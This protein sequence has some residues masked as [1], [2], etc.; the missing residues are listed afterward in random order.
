MPQHDDPDFHIVLLFHRDIELFRLTAA[1]CVDALTNGTVEE[2]ELTIYCDG[3]PPAMMGEVIDLG[4]SLGVDQVVH[5]HRRRAVAAGAPGN[6]AHRRL[7]PTRNRF[8]LAIEDDVTMYRTSGEFDVLH[9][10]RRLFADDAS[11]VVMTKIDDHHKWSWPLVELGRD[12]L[13]E[14]A[15]VN[16]VATHFICYETERF[17][18]DAARFGAWSSDLFVDRSDWSYNWEDLVSHMCTTGDR[19]ILFPKSWPLAVYHCD[20]KISPGS[21]YSDLAAGRVNSDD[22]R[23]PATRRWLRRDAI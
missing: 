16:R 22:L 12:G 14:V 6:N 15:Q 10:I 11:A 18:R 4:E 19:K 1:R 21:M 23:P 8:L 17:C 7:F 13:T 3:T 5:R 20:D 2:F 9:S